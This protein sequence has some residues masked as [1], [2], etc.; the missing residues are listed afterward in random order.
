MYGAEDEI[1]QGAKDVDDVSKMTFRNC[2][3]RLSDIGKATE[4]IL[5]HNVIKQAKKSRPAIYFAALAGAAAMTAAIVKNTI[6]A[7]QVKDQT[8]AISYDKQGMLIDAPDSLSL[9]IILYEYA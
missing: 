7:K 2:A 5:N 4:A 8:V 9:A 6:Q 1:T 3:K